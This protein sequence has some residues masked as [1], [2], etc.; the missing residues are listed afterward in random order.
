MKSL[1]EV[2]RQKADAEI[3]CDLYDWFML[4]E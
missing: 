1:A 4:I 2:L 3:D